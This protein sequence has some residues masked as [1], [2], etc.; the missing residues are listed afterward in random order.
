M[1][2]ADALLIGTHRLIDS[3][4]NKSYTLN[5]REKVAFSGYCF[6]FT[7]SLPEGP[8]LPLRDNVR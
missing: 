5:S 7:V 4:Q 3:K 2:N 6:L 1:L 8:H